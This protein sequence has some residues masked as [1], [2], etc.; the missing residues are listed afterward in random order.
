MQDDK[1]TFATNDV[2][3][4]SFVNAIPFG[5][6][7]KYAAQIYPVPITT[8]RYANGNSVDATGGTGNPK[9]VMG[10]WGSG[11]GILEGEDANGTTKTE[12]VVF[13]F[14]IPPEY[15][16]ADT[17]KINVTCRYSDSGAGTLTTKTID[18]EV[19]EIAEDGTA[20]ADLC[21]TTAQNVT[22]TMTQYEFDITTTNVASGDILRVFLRIT[23]TESGGTGAQKAEFGG[24]A[25]E[26]DIKL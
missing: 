9:L 14:A 13:D 19:Y 7:K 17:I 3:T 24:A 20:S 10:G 11:T 16:D 8:W 12:T 5:N 18:C 23:L 26:L 1:T 22:T 15:I 6:L 2:L 21:T 4:S 25:V